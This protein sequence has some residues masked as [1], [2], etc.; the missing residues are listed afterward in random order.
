M[1]ALVRER[2]LSDNRVVLMVTHDPQDALVAAD[3]IAL[4]DEG[5]ISAPLPTREVL[6]NPPEMLRR[7]LGTNQ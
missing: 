4:V 7:Y 2:A 5:K 1:L 3:Q 6:D